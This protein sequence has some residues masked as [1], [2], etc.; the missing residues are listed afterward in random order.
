M[1]AGLFLFGAS[2][3]SEIVSEDSYKGGLLI[4][5]DNEINIYPLG[6][7]LTIP[8][9]GA[10]SLSVE[11]YSESEEDWLEYP[12][13]IISITGT[14]FKIKASQNETGKLRSGLLSFVKS[15]EILTSISVSQEAPEFIFEEKVDEKGNYNCGPSRDTVI[16]DCKSNV[17][18]MIESPSPDPSNPS[19]TAKFEVIN[20]PNIHYYSPGDNSF[21]LVVPVGLHNED[22]ER[23]LYA[24]PLDIS[25]RE[26][27]GTLSSMTIHQDKYLL[28]FVNSSAS[29]VSTSK[30]FSV[31]AEGTEGLDASFKSSGDWRPIYVDEETMEW[32][33][34]LLNGKGLEYD[35]EN[36]EFPIQRTGANNLNNITVNVSQ[37]DT[38]KDREAVIY[39]KSDSHEISFEVEQ[40]AKTDK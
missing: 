6:A 34:I 14:P 33:E 7:T 22:R 39:L 25:G 31:N 27:Q 12:D 36:K 30:S 4:G 9:Y 37:N 21:K 28:G 8:I 23:I 10:D 2:A 32:V 3:C 17:N 24:Y 38:G 26:M 16:I 13:S 5:A 18:F 20:D 19:D 15:D 11:F 35:S 29:G 1:F 40:K